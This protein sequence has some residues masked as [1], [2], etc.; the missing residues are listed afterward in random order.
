MI[1]SDWLYVIRDRSTK[2]YTF[3]QE[4]KGFHVLFW[5]LFFMILLFTDID[6]NPKEPFLFIFTN[7]LINIIFYIIIVYFNLNYLI[8]H[9]FKWNKLSLYLIILLFFV[10]VLTPLKMIIFYVKF[11]NYPLKQTEIIDSQ[12]D[13]LLIHI[14]VAGFSTIFK[15]VGDWARDQRIKNELEAQNLQ[16]ELNFLKTQINPH[17]L[18]NTLNNL[19]AL[20]L[21]KSEKAP[22]IVIK[23]SEMMRYMLYECNEKEV[24]LVK[25]V[26]YLRNYLDLERLRQAKDVDIQLEVKGMVTNQRIAP[27]LFIPFVE[28]SFKHGLNRQIT[29]GYVHI[30]LHIQKDKVALFV[31]N[32]KAPVMPA[33]NS[34][35]SG[36]IGLVNVKRRLDLLYPNRHHLET[37]DSPNEYEINLEVDLA[38]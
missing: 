12:Y 20:T 8:P 2:L 33:R 18:F 29:D 3:I 4:K 21:K 19:Y 13:F 38:K 25:E 27:L 35:P 23:L 17:F 34:K 26:N 6:A 15:I 31:K 22:E 32:S 11:S 28:N 36:G 1:A 7:E 24:P 37:I 5:L 30:A 10:V 14:L 16:S 9:Y